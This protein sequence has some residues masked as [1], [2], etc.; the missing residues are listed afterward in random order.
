MA[1][2]GVGGVGNSNFLSN[3]YQTQRTRATAMEKLSS[4]LRINKGR[5]DPAG[6]LIS[7]LLRSQIG[8][9]DRALRNTQEANNMMS[10][11]EGGLS[12]VS[13][14][15]SKMR[16]LAVHSLNSGVTTGIQTSADQ[17]EMNSLLSSVNRVVSTT[18]YAGTNLL[19]GSGD[20]TFDATDPAGMIDTA[21]TT[22]SNVAGN[23]PPE[24]SIE[25]T[26][27]SALQAERAYIEAD[28]GDS[29]LAAAQEFTVTGADGSRS[30]S[31]EA[32]TSIEDMAAQINQMADSTGVNAYAIRDEGTGATAM[33]LVSGEYGS[34]AAVRVEQIRGD[35]FAAEG[36]T[37]VDYG[38]DAMI[39]VD[40]RSVTTNGLT[41]E[42]SGGRV[43]GDITFNAEGAAGAPTI[44]QTGYDQD[45]LVD[46][47]AAQQASLNDIRGGMQLQLGE[48]AG[49][50]SRETVAIG[51]YST[52]NLGRVE[53]NG[54][55][56]DLNDMFGGGAAS[57]GNNPELAL[58]IIDQ[59]IADVASGRANIGAYQAN[60][61]DTNA[62]NLMATMENMIATESRIRDA[63]MAEMVIALTQSQLLESAGMYGLQTQNA[64]AQRT[65]QLL[66]GGLSSGR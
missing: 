66:L 11:A 30:F 44:A 65:M 43:S 40:G 4:G 24:I 31:F 9:M 20:F 12:S 21:N 23:I 61:L 26:G 39:R 33:R 25:Y 47:N 53:Y 36:A 28:F 49:S 32:G 38:Q 18:N 37:A 27:D 3:L 51:N 60:T 34:D 22:I 54:E 5:D 58:Q 14:M 45:T 57:L 42:M 7:E 16:N 41:A 52:G 2:M 8:G 62:N 64:N 50:Q 10:V 13:S 46:A 6:L 29:A 35:A 1:A 15:L 48:T 19:N 59:A 56:Y 17:M 63:D 55:T